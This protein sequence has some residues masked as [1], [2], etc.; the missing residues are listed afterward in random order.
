MGILIVSLLSSV[1][2]GAENLRFEGKSIDAWLNILVGLPEQPEKINEPFPGK[3]MQQQAVAAFKRMG[4]R[5]YDYLVQR[6]DSTNA[7]VIGIAFAFKYAGTNASLE[8]RRLIALFDRDEAAGAAIRCLVEIGTNS[9]P[10][11]IEAL[12]EKNVKIR[13]R[14]ANALG[15]I[16]PPAKT[17]VPILMKR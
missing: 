12:S 7:N 9:V 13:Q 5:E 8:I 6:L 1:C 2:F 4:P 15:Q 14:P 10:A 3:E 17:A 16:G 11:L